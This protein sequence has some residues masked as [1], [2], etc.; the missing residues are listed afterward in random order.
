MHRSD[1]RA[2]DVV[3][4]RDGTALIRE[5]LSGTVEVGEPSW[6]TSQH[7]AG[8]APMGAG[9]RVVDR[10]I[11][12]AITSPGPHAI[13]AGARAETLPNSIRRVSNNH[14]CDR[15]QFGYRNGG[16]QTARL[17]D[18]AASKGVPVEPSS[19]GHRR[20]DR[21]HGG[22]GPCRLRPRSGSHGSGFASADR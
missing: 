18:C 6:S 15:R 4:L 13:I 2:E 16:S 5:L 12:P 9:A 11:M 14:V 19:H 21:L 20:R 17:G 22:D 1:T 10:S 3:A 8:T 7:L